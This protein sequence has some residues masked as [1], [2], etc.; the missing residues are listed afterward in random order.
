MRFS[1]K[2]YLVLDCH[3]TRPD[4]RSRSIGT[5]LRAGAA[6]LALLL[7]FMVGAAAPSF[8]NEPKLG[9][10]VKVFVGT[11]ETMD[12]ND[13]KAEAVGVDARGLIVAVGTRED[14][15]HMAGTDPKLVVINLKPRE[16]LLPGFFDAHLHLDALLVKYSGL[17]EM[18]GPCLPGP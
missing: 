9:P 5:S 2:L 8:A 4:G 7:A 16:A 17:A 3:L 13:Q 14:V 10:I 15:L 1:E 6:R 11:I 12:S 18:V